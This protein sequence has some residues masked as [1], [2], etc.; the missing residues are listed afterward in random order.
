M[1]DSFTIKIAGVFVL[2]S[3]AAEFAAG[4]LAFSHGMTP[5]AMNAVD[6]GVGEQLITFQPS[7]MRVLFY[8]AVL[9]PC[10]SMLAWPGMYH[11]LASGGS[12]AFWGVIVSSLAMLLGV[13]AEAVRLS[14]VLTLPS[15]YVAASE[16]TKPGVLILGAFFG[17]LY[18]ILAQTTLVT[19]YAVGTPLIAAAIIRSRNLPSWLGWVLMIPSLLVG[20][21]GGPLLLFGYPAIGGPFVGLGLNVF[22]VW[23]AIIGIVML[24]LQPPRDRAQPISV[25]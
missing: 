14:M 12:S 4:G 24:R 7:W 11:L 16:A 1:M 18:Q 17:H 2:L 25:I 15:A 19:L 6:W 10:L 3:L 22:F 20:Y 9:A 13:V 23:F 8:L 21:V 5:A